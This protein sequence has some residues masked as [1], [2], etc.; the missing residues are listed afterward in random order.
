VPLDVSIKA[1]GDGS[2]AVVVSGSVDRGSG[3]LAPI[4]TTIT[5]DVEAFR[6]I[7]ELVFAQHDRITEAVTLTRHPWDFPFTVGRQMTPTEVDRQLTHEQHTIVYGGREGAQKI[8]D[9]GF[10]RMMVT[11][12]SNN[13]RWFAVRTEPAEPHWADWLRFD[14]AEEDWNPAAA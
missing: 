5:L 8:R 10:H 3:K 4:S 7:W 11:G 13:M 6:P 2:G 9:A 12:G 14:E 1:H